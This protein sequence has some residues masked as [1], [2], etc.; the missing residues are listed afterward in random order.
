MTET[1]ERTQRLAHQSIPQLLMHYAV[2]AIVGT[3]V[4]ALYSVVDRIFIGNTVSEFAISGLALTFPIIIFIQAFGMLIGVGASSRVSI[5][6]GRGDHDGA[7]RILG[8]AV[9]LTFVTQFLVL[10]P[11]MIWM[12]PLLEAFGA[13]ERTLPYA[14]D[15][16][17]II[18]PGNLFSTLCF[19]YNSV[20]RA[21]GY[22]YKAMV[23]MLIGAGL[24]TVLD[25]LFIYGFG[26]G[27]AG[28]AWATVLSMFVSMAFVLA[29]FMDKRSE[30]HFR[31]RNFR[32]SWGEINAILSVGMSPF[33]LQLLSSFVAWLINHSLK[34]SIADPLLADRAIASYGIINSIVLVGF[35]FMMGVAQ[36]MQPIV[37]Y[38]YGAE[39]MDRVKETFKIC[40]LAN[41]TVGLLVSVFGLSFPR[42]MV[43][44]FTNSPALLDVA[45]GTL[46]LVLW[47]FT[48][49]GFQV[50]STQFFQSIGFGGKALL[51][52]LS[53]Q[54][55]F[56]LPALFLFPLWWGSTGVWVSLPFADI[57]AGILGVI[58]MSYQ[59]R[60]FDRKYSARTAA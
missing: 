33:F 30:V 26:W 14:Y 17:K 42:F 16:L 40:V 2:P 56:L 10:I 22:P 7:E 6:L 8:N 27:I 52:S 20:M 51:L 59:F 36:G 1:S 19:S 32:F 13:N 41:V 37:G 29:H 38:N 25:A 21:S 24:N 48:F 12:R 44:L 34:S 3:M 50:T 31:R 47:G 28:A 4:N 18:V 53:R 5:L 9:L 60:L 49:V 58:L 54:V 46:R 35:M 45:S 15:Y 43:S 55:L 39:A 11:V 57:C 23:T